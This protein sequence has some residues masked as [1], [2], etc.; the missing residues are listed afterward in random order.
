M[1][2]NWIRKSYMASIQY[3]HFYKMY[4]DKKKKR[5]QVTNSKECNYFFKHPDVFND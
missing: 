2:K 4:G 3:C 1:I 5:S